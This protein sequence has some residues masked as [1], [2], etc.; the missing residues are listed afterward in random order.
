MDELCQESNDSEAE[1]SA[2]DEGKN[3]A[4]MDPKA[5][6]LGNILD[7]WEDECMKYLEREPESR[8]RLQ[9]EVRV[10]VISP[11]F[12][13]GDRKASSFT[14]LYEK[15]FK[16]PV[17]SSGFSNAARLCRAM[18]HVIERTLLNERG[19]LQLVDSSKNHRIV[20][21]IRS[22]LR[23]VVYDV[24]K[25]HPDGLTFDE[26]EEECS[27]LLG[28]PLDD[29]L[30]ENGYDTPNVQGM[31][32]DMIDIAFINET[33]MDDRVFLSKRAEDPALTDGVCIGRSE[34]VMS[35]CKPDFDKL[36][37]LSE[38][39]RYPTSAPEGAEQDV[40]D[41]IYL[42]TQLIILLPTKFL[43]TSIPAVCS[44]V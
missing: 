15:K 19:M 43:K 14:T 11:L 25:L 24:L 18:P 27:K 42:N 28:L 22:G 32:R 40:K 16:K 4:E 44:S 21:G 29:V 7:P 31:L 12:E 10:I 34:R 5:V 3:N 39:Q 8:A 38:V 20:A 9:Y 26:V 23:R 17:E 36:G 13:L 37:E 2:H 30:L 41:G 1:A 33:G 6:K 35:S